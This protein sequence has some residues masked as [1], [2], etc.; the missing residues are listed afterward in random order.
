MKL[1]ERVQV[2]WKGELLDVVSAEEARKILENGTGVQ[3]A[4]NQI[5]MTPSF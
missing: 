3:I 5:K 2:W 4:E 1:A